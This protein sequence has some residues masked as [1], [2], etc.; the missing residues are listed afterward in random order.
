MSSPICRDPRF[1]VVDLGL[2]ITCKLRKLPPDQLDAAVRA[3]T[4]S[5][6]DRN[7]AIEI[8]AQHGTYQAFTEGDDESKEYD[9]VAASF[10]EKMASF[11]VLHVERAHVDI[12]CFL[13][14]LPVHF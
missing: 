7:E 13:R 10:L 1:Y 9:Y 6:G 8:L 3:M 14:L 11:G 4:T 5:E 2:K 12:C